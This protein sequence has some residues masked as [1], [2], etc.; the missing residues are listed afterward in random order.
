M[1]VQGITQEKKEARAE[2]DEAERYQKMQ[3]ELVRDHCACR[4]CTA[5][6]TCMCMYV[7]FFL[8]SGEWISEG[9][10]FLA[11]YM[12]IQ[13]TC[14]T[15]TC[16]C[17]YQNYIHVHVFHIL[18][19]SFFLTRSFLPPSLPLSLSPSLP[20]PLSL[21]PSPSLPPSLSPSLP[22]SLP[23]SLSPSL[24]QAECQ[25]QEHLFKLHHNERAI[26]SLTQDVRAKQKELDRMVSLRCFRAFSQASFGCISII[27]IC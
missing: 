8:P 25:L 18:T 2:R 3:Q 11:F 17:S 24:P 22:P 10:V 5:V 1:C 19:P 4:T 9:C 27:M 6:C 20:L 15:C 23:P 26:N 21:P 16:T 7:R 12:Y 13:C 14:T